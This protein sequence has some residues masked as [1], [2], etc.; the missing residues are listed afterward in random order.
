TRSPPTPLFTVTA[1]DELVPVLPAASFA[2]AVNV[3]V[4]LA[5]VPEFHEMVKGGVTLLP[6]WTLSTY[7]YTTFT[8]TLSEVLT[9]TPI[10]PASV[11]PLE[12]EIILIVGAVTSPLPPPPFGGLPFEAAWINTPASS[13]ARNCD[14]ITNGTL[15]M[16][17]MSSFT[18][19]NSFTF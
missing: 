18:A 9:C 11:A 15:L 8:P 13:R 12:G 5:I 10:V 3:C 19:P 2:V 4:P 7:R 14:E 1:V 17:L 16:A 6:T